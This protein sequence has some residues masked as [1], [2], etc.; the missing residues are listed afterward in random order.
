MMPNGNPS[1]MTKSSH[2]QRK[3]PVIVNAYYSHSVSSSSQGLKVSSFQQPTRAL[4]TCC[5]SADGSHMDLNGPEIGSKQV[6]WAQCQSTQ[7]VDIN[8][9]SGKNSQLKVYLQHVSNQALI[10]NKIYIRST[11]ITNS[12]KFY[13]HCLLE[14]MLGHE[15]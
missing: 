9:H 7:L 4:F 6:I 1:L 15:H 10:P 8:L 14:A 12:L 3:L 2:G 13:T 5:F 11:P